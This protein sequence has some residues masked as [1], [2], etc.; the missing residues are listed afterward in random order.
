MR[1][2][3]RLNVPHAPALPHVAVQLIPALP[4]LGAATAA[5]VDCEPVLRVEGR[6][7]VA[8][9]VTSI[10]AAVT[11][12]AVVDADLLGSLVDVAVIVIV[13][14]EPFARFPRFSV[15]VLPLMIG[16]PAVDT[17]EASCSP[18]GSVWLKTTVCARSG[19]LLVTVN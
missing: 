10:G 16:A 19:P 5:S 6:D 18:A 17:A 7:D 9:I 4:V 3:E 13:T 1:A 15:I 14:D 12:V 2:G 8:D 11:T